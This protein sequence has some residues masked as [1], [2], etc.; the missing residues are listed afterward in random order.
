MISFYSK[1]DWETFGKKWT[2]DEKIIID[3]RKCRSEQDVVLSIGD[4]LRASYSTELQ[5]GNSLDALHDLVADWFIEQWNNWND[6]YIIGWKRFIN[7]HPFFSQKILLVLT[8]SYL[9][10]ITCQM[11]EVVQ[12]KTANCSSMNF[13]DAMHENPPKIFLVMN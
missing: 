12:W 2:D 10:S 7:E 8:D 13:L 5:G 6:I 3:L 9:T 4:I 11:R 1:K